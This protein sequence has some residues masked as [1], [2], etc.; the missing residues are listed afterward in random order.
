MFFTDGAKNKVSTLL[1]NK[2]K[3]CLGAFQKSF[4]Q[5]AATA[6]S[7]FRLRDI[8]SKAQRIGVRIDQS[9]DA[10]LLMRLQNISDNIIHTFDHH[11]NGQS[12][13]GQ[14]SNAFEF[15]SAHENGQNQKD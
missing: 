1:W 10:V 9:L 14:Q 2:I 8:P 3:L 6:D 7:N 13:C 11:H 15:L 4:S 12:S 5:K